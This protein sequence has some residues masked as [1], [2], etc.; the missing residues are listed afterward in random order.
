MG[1]RKLYDNS[2]RKARP[3]FNALVIQEVKNACI[4]LDIYFPV[5]LLQLAANGLSKLAISIGV[6]TKDEKA[7]VT[8]ADIIK[9][10]ESAQ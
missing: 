3:M 5:P 2:I 9:I 10:E 7:T 1:Y 6:C 4:A 8:E